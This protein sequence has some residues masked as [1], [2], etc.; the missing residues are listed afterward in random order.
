MCRACSTNV[1]S[2]SSFPLSVFVEP[3]MDIDESPTRKLPRLSLRVRVA[4]R[5]YVALFDRC[6]R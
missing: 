3:D 6:V 1:G 5:N 2:T 4:K